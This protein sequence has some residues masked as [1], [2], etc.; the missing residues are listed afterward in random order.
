MGRS[1]QVRLSAD[2]TV[3]SFASDVFATTIVSLFVKVSI[4]IATLGLSISVYLQF[5]FRG[6]PK[7]RLEESASDIHANIYLV[8]CHLPLFLALVSLS[9]LSLVL[10]GASY[11]VSPMATI[12]VAGIM[13]TLAGLP[14]IVNVIGSMGAVRAA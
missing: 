12:T 1:T 8:Q 10:I 9:G 5:K 11:L 7:Q 3:L 4:I 6:V 2:A 13:A 14:L